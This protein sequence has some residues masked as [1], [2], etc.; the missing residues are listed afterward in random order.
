MPKRIVWAIAFD[1]YENAMDEE[2][3]V[4]G[5]FIDSSQLGDELKKMIEEKTLELVEKGQ[6]DH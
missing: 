5:C 3:L 2:P 1:I 6:Y 4:N